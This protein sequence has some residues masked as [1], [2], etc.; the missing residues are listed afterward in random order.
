MGREDVCFYR[1]I[2][3]SVSYCKHALHAQCHGCNLASTVYVYI[4]VIPMVALTSDNNGGLTATCNVDGD[5]WQQP[6]SDGRL[7]CLP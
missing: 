1:I 5:S 7:S 4:T 2:V 3:V 6:E